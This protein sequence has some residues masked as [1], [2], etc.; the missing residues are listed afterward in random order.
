MN[1]IKSVFTKAKKIIKEKNILSIKNIIIFIALIIATVIFYQYSMIFFYD[2]TQY[3]KMA[4]IILGS[5]P[6]SNWNSVRGFTYPLYLAISMF[7]FGKSQFGLKTSAYIIY[8]ITNIMGISLLN[9]F[10]KNFSNRKKI[11]VYLLFFVFIVFNPMFI[12][13]MHT[14]LTEQLAPLFYITCLLICYYWNKDEFNKKKSFIFYSITLS[15]ISIL[16]WFLKQPYIIGYYAIIVLSIITNFIGRK[17][18]K[19]LLKQFIILLISL[20]S[21]FASIKI[22]DIVLTK[23]GIASSSDTNSQIVSDVLYSGTSVYFKKITKEEF[24]N[25][26]FLDEIKLSNKKKNQL[27]DLKKK[28]SKDWCDN[29]VIYKYEV[30]DKILD[31]E[32][33]IDENGDF[34]TLDYI[35]LLTKS[36]YNHPSGVIKSY[37]HNYMAIIDLENILYGDQYGYRATSIF[38]GSA[39]LENNN[40]PMY[41]YYKDMPTIWYMPDKESNKENIVAGLED[42][43]QYTQDKKDLSQIM[44]LQFSMIYY[45]YKVSMLLSVFIF[46]YS[47]ILYIKTKLPKYNVLV[48]ICGAVFANN[49]FQ[50]AM[51]AVVDRYTYPLSILLY[52][53]IIILLFTNNDDIKKK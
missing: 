26:Q 38:S 33:I 9:K 35:E 3:Y 34:S 52:I 40:L 44:F 53:G 47:F 5:E 14:I 6:F 36:I 11:F 25:D 30:E 13:Y 15:I 7:L 29:L 32:F 45:T 20:A 49:M 8:M 46:I 24:C 19:I 18:K 2:S 23:N 51:G 42:Y 50:T 4:N 12:G 48:L 1:F 22:W 10:S 21:I 31:Y 17:S 16:F 41:I 28:N 43:E 37:F 39:G 27:L